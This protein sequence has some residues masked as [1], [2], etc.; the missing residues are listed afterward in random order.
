MPRPLVAMFFKQL[1]IMGKNLLTQFHDDRTINMA[2][3][4]LTWFYY[5]YIRKNAT[6]LGGHVFP[7]TGTIFENSS[8]I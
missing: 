3:R 7:P 6:P 5:N 8:K 1:D 4:V 2:S